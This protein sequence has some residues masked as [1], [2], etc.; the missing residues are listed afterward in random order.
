MNCYMVVS[1]CGDDIF[2]SFGTRKLASKEI[3]LSFLLH[4]RMKIYFELVPLSISVLVCYCN[5][6]Q[7]EYFLADLNLLRTYSSPFLFFFFF[8][9]CVWRSYRHLC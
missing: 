5:L 8:C 3:P 4:V 7:M 6:V 9:V 2:W 1:A